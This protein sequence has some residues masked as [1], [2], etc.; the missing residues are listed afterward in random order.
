MLIVPMT[1][2]RPIPGRN[3]TMETKINA[4]PNVIHSNDHFE[5][6]RIL[7]KDT[8]K[9]LDNIM[10]SMGDGLS[11]QD[12]DLKIVYQNKFIIDNFGSHVGDY[13][14]NVYEKRSAAC[15]G[16]PMIESYRTG[17]VTK[18]LRVGITKNGVPF[19]FENIASVLR[20]DQG[21][22]VAGIELCR[23]VEE[24]E[25]AFDELKEATEKLKRTQ[26][27]LVRSEKLAGIGQLA[28][29]VAHEINNPTGFVLS[30]LST[31]RKYVSEFFTYVEALEKLVMA[32]PPQ[33]E[34]QQT[35]RIRDGVRNIIDN[36]DYSYL[37]NVLPEVIEESLNGLHRIKTIVSSLMR[38]ASSGEAGQ[39]MV[40]P[41]TEIESA[42]SLLENEIGKKGHVV[43]MLGS[44][45]KIFANPQQ[46]GQMFVNLLL[47]ATQAIEAG[48]TITVKTDVEGNYVSIQIADDGVG[49]PKDVIQNIFNP[50]FTTREVG[51]G[52]GL[53]LS[54]AYRIIENHNG[55]IDVQSE[56]GHGTTF[57]IRLPFGSPKGTTN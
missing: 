24:R 57:T 21:E 54:I 33:G 36:D 17:Q 25:R 38:F 28:A 11:I 45:P 51:K 29:G 52:V 49:I 22:I 16:C 50:F 19:R 37:K 44:L 20:N 35:Q 31:M 5:A 8:S 12:R 14:Y 55:N 13:C 40:D 39:C 46:L 34:Q 42:L 48:G 27:R 18:A 1:R 32:T 2:H 9:I 4:S 23:I 56:P 15:D 53:G 47:N 7:L 6:V 26:S 3:G 30:N 10:A 41:N 43:K